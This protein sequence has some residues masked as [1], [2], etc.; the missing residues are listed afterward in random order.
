MRRKMA[1]AE[2]ERE[3]EDAKRGIR[4]LMKMDP[5]SRVTENPMLAE[6]V[7]TAAYDPVRFDEPERATKAPKYE[8][9]SRKKESQ[10]SQP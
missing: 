10:H 7:R 9:P 2:L 4:S 6:R 8:E 1:W 5:E 3:H